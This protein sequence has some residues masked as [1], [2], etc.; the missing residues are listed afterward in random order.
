MLANKLNELAILSF[1]LLLI[2][3]FKFAIHFISPFLLS[4]LI[5]LSKL[6]K[7][8]FGKKLKKLKKVFY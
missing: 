8:I 7:K 6:T 5:F 2:P 1:D 3:S 4:P